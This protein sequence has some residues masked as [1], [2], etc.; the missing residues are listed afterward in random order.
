MSYSQPHRHQTN[1]SILRLLL[2]LYLLYLYL[3]KIEDL[4]VC[5][6]INLK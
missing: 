5:L 2:L 4:F 6:L 1:P 3:I